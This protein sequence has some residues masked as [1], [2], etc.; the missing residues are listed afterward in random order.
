MSK[1][2]KLQW[3][4]ARQTARHNQSN[5][6]RP[7]PTEY[8]RRSDPPMLRVREEELV[9]EDEAK[10]HDR[11][12]NE[13]RA[14]RMPSIV[15]E[16][17]HSDRESHVS[18]IREDTIVGKRTGSVHF[19]HVDMENSILSTSPFQTLFQGIK[20]QYASYYEIVDMMRRLALTCGTV[21]CKTLN[22]L[23]LFSLCI[24]LFA[25]LG[26]TQLEPYDEQIMDNL[27]AAAHWQ[28]L[29]SIIVLLIRDANMF[30]SVHYEIT[31]GV[32]VVTNVFMLLF[33]FVPIVPD[34]GRHL[35]S[36]LLHMLTALRGGD[37]GKPS[38]PNGTSPTAAA[39]GRDWA[40]R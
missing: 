36:L 21:I 7:R 34:I 32:L 2:S 17:S 24:A 20:P 13:M 9:G 16:G 19:A 10:G 3:I 4:S 22:G 12:D 31:G 30:E 18:T 5:R 25:L 15:H 37:G 14:S 38:G 35:R 39:A 26:H 8:T 11:Q 29:L 33:L 28:T 23:V 6:R 1:E 40:H 27:V